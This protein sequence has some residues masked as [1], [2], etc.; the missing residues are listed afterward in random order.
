MWNTTWTQYQGSPG[1]SGYIAVRTAPAVQPSRSAGIWIAGS[2]PIVDPQNGSIYVAGNGGLLSAFRPDL[3][4]LWE[5]HAAGPNWIG[6]TPAQDAAGRI[7][8]IFENPGASVRTNKL[9]CLTRSGAPLWQYAPP[10][11]KY[12]GTTSPE[13][14]S[15][16]FG[17]PKVW[18]RG[19]Q[20]LVFVVFCYF[21]RGSRV[22]YLLALNE[23]GI[24]V[25][26]VLYHESPWIDAS[27]GFRVVRD[28]ISLSGMLSDEMPAHVSVRPRMLDG[29]C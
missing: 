27:S 2:S 3:T 26:L 6:S 25:G 14:P 20:T 17:P 13:Y 18:S 29:M 24:P 10:P 16:L 12:P 1:N 19:T 11:Q 4:S 7:Y 9:V 5:F 28:R 21:V 22:N 15:F 8:A 23:R